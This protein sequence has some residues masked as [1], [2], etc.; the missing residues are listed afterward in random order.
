MTIKIEIID[1]HT[2]T[3]EELVNVAKF[4]MSI[5]RVP[6]VAVPEGTIAPTNQREVLCEPSVV[7]PPPPLAHS[8]EYKPVKQPDGEVLMMPIEGRD[9]RP[10]VS[11]LFNEPS[12]PYGE[13]HFDNTKAAE[14]FKRPPAPPTLQAPE[15][16][17]WNPEI[18]SRTKSKHPDGSYKLKRGSSSGR[19]HTAKPPGKFEIKEVGETTITEE[20]FL[21]VPPPPP[22][23]A[24]IKSEPPEAAEDVFETMM[25]EMLD[26]FTN[27][28]LAAGDIIS[29]ANEHGVAS[30]PLLSDHPHLWPLLRS[31]IDA[32]IKLRG[33]H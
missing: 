23:A 29:F 15:S 4:L 16:D 12:D 19:S 33:H 10:G 27:G 18:H 20:D 31:K 25:N 24:P 7:P 30:I 2:H 28:K 26:H 1:P 6:M 21:P 17:G 32:L 5:A 8:P 3:A 11:A 9:L 13:E 14:V 22:P